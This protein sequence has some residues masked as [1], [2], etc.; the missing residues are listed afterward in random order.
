M[1]SKNQPSHSCLKITKSVCQKHFVA[2]ESLTKA[3]LLLGNIIIGQSSYHT[4]VLFYRYTDFYIKNVISRAS[5]NSPS[6]TEQHIWHPVKQLSWW[7]VFSSFELF[8]L[9]SLDIDNVLTRRCASIEHQN[10]FRSWKLESTISKY[11]YTP[12]IWTFL[13]N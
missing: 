12:F 11:S 4:C 8:E 13:L 9:V 5:P 1:A 7:R 3:T 10:R 6:G 2:L